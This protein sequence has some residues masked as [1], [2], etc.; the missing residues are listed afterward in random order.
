MN[1]SDSKP[2]CF[3]GGAMDEFEKILVKTIDET[4]KW[5]FGEY[6]SKIIYDY[7][8]R[9]SCPLNEVPKKP[10]IFSIELRM[11]LGSGRGSIPGSAPILERA[12]IKRLCSKL[13]LNFNQ[14][15]PVNFPKCVRL[16]RE[17]Y[18]SGGK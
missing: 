17:V 7:L 1:Y 10:E 6:T 12:I 11:I 3:A 4:I 5:T 8:E 15:G 9:R 16:L 13:G 14:K 18:N 2:E